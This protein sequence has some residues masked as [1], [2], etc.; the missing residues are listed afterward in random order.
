MNILVA[1]EESQ[2]V[3]KAFRELG[4]AAYSCDVVECSGGH[5]EWHI[6]D[7][8]LEYIN[9]NG[10]ANVF[11]TQDGCFHSFPNKWDLIIAHPPC[12][13]LSNAGAR[14]LWKN[15]QLNKDRFDK[16]MAAKD[17]FLAFLNA[18]CDYIAVEN[19]VP[20]KVFELPMYTQ[21]IQPYEYGYPYSKRTCLWLKGLPQLKP[22]NIV[23]P[24]A[25]WC[26]SSSYSRL[27]AEKY[28]GMF[29]VDRSRKRSKTFA[30]I[31]EAMAVQWGSI[32]GAPCN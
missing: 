22:T 2:T 28:R 9:G 3:C 10:F 11:R 19:P 8:A 15:H 27:H 29:T 14:H 25:T 17:F 5:P 32:I 23:A 7:D 21:I 24:V 26:P 30:G 12:T 1:C 18:D 31:A 20:S 6:H 16:G 4:H 13:Y